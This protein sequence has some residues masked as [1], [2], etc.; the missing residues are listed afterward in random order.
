MGVLNRIV[1]IFD[2]DD[3]AIRSMVSAGMGAIV[4][5]VNDD[6]KRNMSKFSKAVL[7]SLFIAF[8]CGKYIFSKFNITDV[9][10][11]MAIGFMIGITS[12]ILI[13]KVLEM[14]RRLKIK[15]PK[16]FSSVAEDAGD[17]K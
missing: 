11:I 7:T 6:E 5:G 4:W 10:A 9:G 1:E 15:M 16:F 8:C 14:L 3:D 12:M 13:P 17:G 2:I